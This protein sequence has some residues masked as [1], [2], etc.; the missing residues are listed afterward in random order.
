MRVLAIETSTMLGGIAIMDDASGLVA[1]VRVNVKTAHSERLMAELDGALKQAGLGLK[2]IDALAVSAGPG[3]FTG[4]RIGLGTVKGLSFAT[5]LPVVAVPTLEAFAW[6]LPGY[7][8]VCPMLDARKK[9][10]YAALYGHSDGGFV[11]IM[12]E[13]VIAP[14]ELVKRLSEYEGVC[15]AGEGAAIYK[16]VLIDALGK[17]AVFAPAHLMVPSPASVALIGLRMALRGQFADPAALAPVYIR[18]S[19]AEVKLE[20]RSGG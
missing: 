8:L 12:K 3:S 14:S 13:T 4:L 19:E 7:P 17:R 15:F 1:E 10:V 11:N 18:K 2:D 5:G 16:D 20:E 9:E 6:A